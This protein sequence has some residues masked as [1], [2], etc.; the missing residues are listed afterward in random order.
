LS[1]TKKPASS[2]GIVDIMSEHENILKFSALQRKDL[3]NQAYELWGKQQLMVAIEE[4]SELSQK[5]IHAV[6]DEK[7]LTYDELASE[8]ADV[9]IMLEQVK[10][11]FG[12]QWLVEKHEEEKLQKLSKYIKEAKANA[13]D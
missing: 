11:Q 8:V 12:I 6:R 7:E 5:L 4:M 10:H 2:K 9:S 3:Y 1:G 13:E